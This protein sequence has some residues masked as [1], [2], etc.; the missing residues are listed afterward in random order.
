MPALTHRRVKNGF[1]SLS[2]GG[3]QTR[4]SNK[5]GCT[6]I[7]CMPG[8]SIQNNNMRVSNGGVRNRIGSGSSNGK[9]ALNVTVGRSFGAKRAISRRVSNSYAIKDQNGT[10]LLNNDGFNVSRKFFYYGMIPG[11]NIDNKYTVC[12]KERD[13]ICTSTDNKV[14]TPLEPIDQEGEEEESELNIAPVV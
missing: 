6:D 1:N 14:Y 13:G 4:I 3:G 12:C 10:T 9:L 2:S 7:C 11:M 5:P 8:R